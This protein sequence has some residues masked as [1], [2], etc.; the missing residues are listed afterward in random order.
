MKL[1][2]VLVYKLWMCMMK[3]NPGLKNIKG[4]YSR[5]T[6]ICAGQEGGELM[7]EDKGQ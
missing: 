7:C 6:I 5:E 2:T 3:D 1:Y 4:D